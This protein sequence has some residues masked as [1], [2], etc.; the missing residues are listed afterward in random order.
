[1]N[2]PYIYIYIHIYFSNIKWSFKIFGDRIIISVHSVDHYCPHF[3]FNASAVTEAKIPIMDE[4][5]WRV[6]I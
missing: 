2:Y 1:M 4:R 6:S 3:D 5:W